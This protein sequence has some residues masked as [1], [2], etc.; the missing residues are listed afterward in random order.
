[1]DARDGRRRRLAALTGSALIALGV[2]APTAPA[3]D[4][5]DAKGRLTA[6]SIDALIDAGLAAEGLTASDRCSD[7][8]FVRRAYLDLNGTI[9]SFEETEA[10]LADGYAD[11]R[12][13]L[14]ER[15]LA[16]EGFPEYWAMVLE[17]VFVGRAGQMQRFDRPGFRRFLREALA[18]GTGY[19]AIVR[20]MLCAT[21]DGREV[22][23][24]G[25]GLRYDGRPADVI[26]AASRALLGVQ[27]QCAQ[28]HNHPYEK[29]TSG[30]FRDF[31]AFFG[32]IAA[33]PVRQPDP[34]DPKNMRIVSYEL[35]DLEKGG[36]AG[37]GMGGM[38]GGLARYEKL[39][40][41]PRA[42]ARL[43]KRL[44][45]LR[46]RSAPRGPPPWAMGRAER[47]SP[48]GCWRRATRTSRAPP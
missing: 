17:N 40:N 36:D 26:G 24:A 6:N 46:G 35:L 29:W 15:L 16:S 41:N 23:A 45:E 31:A 1:M 13:R 21:G 42:K 19:D 5:G 30:D 43:E 4:G 20:E 9:P 38:G 8:D 47:P 14:V 3:G 11:K 7:A 12:A 48:T 32:T 27:I 28:C 33:R 2:A 22:G 37:Y 25:F 44:A 10:F 18:A 39:K 34:R